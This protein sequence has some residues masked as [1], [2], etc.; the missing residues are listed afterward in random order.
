MAYQNITIGIIACLMC[1][2]H[3]RIL[4]AD[5]IQKFRYKRELKNIEKSW[6]KVV[7]PVDIYEKAASNLSDVRVLGITDAGDTVEAPYILQHSNPRQT[8]TS[9]VS[10]IIN[11]SRSAAGYHFTLVMPPNHSTDEIVLQFFEQNF[12]WRVTIEGSQDLGSWVTL[13]EKNRI[14]SIVNQNTDFQYGTVEFP[15]SVFRYLRITVHSSER[16]HLKS[17]SFVAEENV[18]GEVI[19]YPVSFT[20]Q[21]PENNKLHRQIFDVELHGTRPVSQIKLNVNSA[22]DFYRN[23]SISV[24]T[25][26]V[27]TNKGSFIQYASVAEFVVS[28][29]DT[30]ALLLPNTLGSTFRITIQNNNNSPLKIAGINVLGYESSLLTRI[31]QSARYFLVYGNSHCDTPHYDIAHFLQKLQ[32]NLNVVQLGVE[33]IQSQNSSTVLSTA[34]FLNRN[35]LIGVILVTV[36]ILVWLTLKMIKN[37]STATEE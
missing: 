29:V 34:S 15:R 24:A 18:P 10:E 31:D 35:V 8:N 5:H 17:A 13:A 9:K 36:A 25:D 11:E 23:V 1:V 37:K 27:Q 30:S 4:S 7:L 14:V 20:E 32:T 3:H 12:D 16:P 26:T 19:S 22:V 21:P 33:E 2:A 6:N 28:S